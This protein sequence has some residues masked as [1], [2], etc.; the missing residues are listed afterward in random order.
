MSVEVDT[1]RS[2]EVPTLVIYS[3]DDQVVDPEA[4]EQIMARITA[5]PPAVYVVD[6]S[7]DAEHHVIVG[8]ILSPETTG[9]IRLRTLAFLELLLEPFP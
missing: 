1:V 6:G 3:A 4:T 5:E 7:G 9:V 2:V 8:D